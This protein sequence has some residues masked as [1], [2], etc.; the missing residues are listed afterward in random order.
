VVWAVVGGLAIGAAAGSLVGRF[1]VYLRRTHKEA[2][3]LDDFLSLGL[4]ALA[5]GAA[6]AAH[7]YGFLAAFAAG[8]ALRRVESAA[9]AEAPAYEPAPDVSAA[10]HAGDAEK[11]AT[12]AKTA[13]AY[14]ASA[15]LGFNEQ[16]E[17]MFEVALVLLLGGMLTRDY[18]PTE[19]IWFVPLLLL[20]IRPLAVAIGLVGSPAASTTQRGLVSWFGIRGIGSVYYL[21]YAVNHGLDAP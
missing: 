18:L 14:M 11:V 7:T 1:V 13:P 3:G 9:A 16:L 19:A 2:V 20:V 15:V 5:Y 21:M 10:A 17:R 4:L 12:D 6:L 8:L